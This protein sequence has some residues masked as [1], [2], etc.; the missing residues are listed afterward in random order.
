MER[1]S[2][3][4]P[5]PI[6]SAPLPEVINHTPWPSQYFQ[7][8]D[9]HG[10]IFHVMVS[11]I[12]YSLLE[13]DASNGLPVPVL[14]APDKQP[15]L[16]ESD[17]FL[18]EP[19][20][21]SLVQ[22]SDYAPYKPKCD[23]LLVNATAHAPGGKPLERWPVG[24]R[25]GD[26]I[27]KR[28][29]VTGPRRFERSI[30]S[31]G[32]LQLS[33]PEPVME[34]PLCY[35]LAFGG[36]SLVRHER[37]LQACVDGEVGAH[38]SPVQRERAARALAALPDAY[39]PNPIGCGHHPAAIAEA[40][41][42]L[43]ELGLSGPSE[44]HAI[45]GRRGPQI[46]AFQRPYD[47]QHDY[48]VLGVGPV[49]RWWSP[50]VALAGTHNEQWK[51]TQWPKSPLDH[52]YRY[53]NCAPEDQQIEYPQGG[54]EVVLANLA[55]AALHSGPYRFQF[56]RQDLQLLVRLH[57]GV[58]M[59]AP[60]HIDTVVM[61]LGAGVLSIVRR[62]VVSAK[63]EVRQLEL[64]TWPAGTGLQLDASMRQLAQAKVASRS[65]HGR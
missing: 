9:P 14:L 26:V 43:T 20:A 64:G 37:L 30:S 53:W 60:M 12:S 63:T 11:R 35:E 18:G 15:A 8:V 4:L 7:H 42:V 58:V 33:R 49:G 31:M 13:L 55:S 22:E 38:L 40:E 56:P 24:F 5:S 23:V 25:F 16:C 47:A 52:N 21:S 32:L 3:T 41:S 54:E 46:E 44:S 62:A 34:V 45:D 61:N 28:L 17:E 57:V 59:F 29:Q 48:P 36:P 1:P 10:E 6:A 2:H 50:R 19:N 39:L 27:E 51:Q 65:G